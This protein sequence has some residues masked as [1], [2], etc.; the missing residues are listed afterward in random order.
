MA[1]PRAGLFLLILF[2][3]DIPQPLDAQ[4]DLSQYADD[5]EDISQSE[6]QVPSISIRSNLRLQKYLNQILTWSDR[7]RIKLNTRKI[8]LINFNSN[9]NV[10]STAKSYP[11]SPWH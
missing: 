10:W 1:L 11:V 8:H 9:Y 5:N 7:W 4:V 6:A 3:S 2:V